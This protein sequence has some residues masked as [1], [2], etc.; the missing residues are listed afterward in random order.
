MKKIIT[1]ISVLAIALTGCRDIY[2]NIGDNVQGEKIYSDKFD[3]IISVK[4][5]FE[6]AEID[7]MKAG[8]IPAGQIRM[9][10]AKKTVIECPDFT[11][12][13]H[14]R[15][16]D[17][18]CSWVNVTG[19]TQ[20]KNYELTIYSE[21][22]FGNRSLA[23]KTTVTPYTAE[24]LNA[25]KMPSPDVVESTSA[26]LLEWKS[27]VSNSSRLFS[28]YRW[29]YEYSDKDGVKHSGNDDGDMPRYFVENV[30]KGDNVPVKMVLKIV[31]RRLV[32]TD[33]YSH[34]IDTVDWQTEV[35]LKIS[36]NAQPAIFLKTPDPAIVFD[37]N[38]D[39]FPLTFSWIPVPEVTDYTLKISAV[40][41]F[42]VASSII[43]NVGNTSEY[44]YDKA[45]AIALIRH[46]APDGSKTVF[47]TV[48]PTSGTA[49]INI[50]SRQ[51][52]VIRPLPNVVGRW[53]FDDPNNLT[54][55]A[56]GQDLIPTGNGFLSV[57][58]VRAGDKAVRISKNSYYKCLHG[59]I[60]PSPTGK[61]SAYTI[62]LYVRYPKQELHSLY[63]TDLTNTSNGVCIM[64]AAGLI[65][66][67]IIGNSTERTGPGIWYRIVLSFSSTTGYKIFIDG[68][69]VRSSVPTGANL[70]RC[71]LDPAGVLLFADDN[72]ED[73]EMDV[74]EIVIWDDAISDEELQ[75]YSGLKRLNKTDWIISSYSSHDAS[76][77]VKDALTDVE[78]T[79]WMS[80]NVV[81]PHWIVFDMQ[82]TH[83]VGRI[84]MLRRNAD[85][86]DT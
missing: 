13:D 10:R 69:Q 16:I 55:A 36:E 76:Y 32:G 63:Q 8:R 54:K 7:L 78:T 41:S 5:G 46:L 84:F 26:A 24:N 52:M 68:E 2:D 27:P 1:S 40:A 17:S 75:K 51:L 59:L 72:G 33:T 45:A 31:P 14:R 35:I 28:C 79:F 22:D 18:I 65:G 80:G 70:E 49:N 50:Q 64:S 81:P 15:V 47:W 86:A 73:N 30:R 6:R 42:P 62:M 57:D 71:L 44:I 61:V 74:S 53:T 48:A 37:S 82:S 4:I 25:I 23:L 43:V 19:L 83:T 34:I 56:V 3:G 77:P 29:S 12:P 11:E 38:D 66:G 39:V 9:G 58:G 21:D 60:P 67:S 20:S 85:A